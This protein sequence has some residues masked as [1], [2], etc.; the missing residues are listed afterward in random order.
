MALWTSDGTPAGTTLVTDLYPGPWHA[1]P[2]FFTS[3]NGELLFAAA[4]LAAAA[5]LLSSLSGAALPSDN[6][7]FGEISLSGAVRPASHMAIRLKEAQKLGFS[8]AVV[9]SNSEFERGATKLK[10]DR[11]DDLKQLAERLLACK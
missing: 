2:V 4:D 6:V 11:L 8:R 7:Y 10:L 5:A 3:R 9:P 1:D